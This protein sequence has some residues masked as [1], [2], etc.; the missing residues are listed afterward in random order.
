M[1]PALATPRPIPIGTAIGVDEMM[2]ADISD[3][4]IPLAPIP[5]PKRPE[6]PM[7]ALPAL[8]SAVLTP[9]TEAAVTQAAARREAP[10][11]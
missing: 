9:A 10:A 4:V 6:L 11:L 7:T 3:P 5:V 2:P 1:T 8:V